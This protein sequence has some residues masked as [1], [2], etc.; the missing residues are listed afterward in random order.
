MAS[1]LKKDGV[2]DVMCENWN[3]SYNWE[4]HSSGLLCNE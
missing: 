4:L 1:H 3:T 2:F